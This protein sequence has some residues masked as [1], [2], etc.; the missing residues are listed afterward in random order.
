M[1]ETVRRLP[2]PAQPRQPPVHS[3]LGVND[4]LF[5]LF[6]HKLMIL[7]FAVA[8][9][10]AGITAYF[11]YPPVYES[12]AKLFVRYVMERSGVDPIDSAN[13]A[14][15][16]AVINAEVEILTSW[17]LAVQV[18]DA[19]GPKKMLPEAGDSASKEAA[20]SRV[21]SGLSV[22]GR[23]GSNIILVSYQ[24]RDPQLTMLVLNELV[25]R[26]FNRHLEVH[27]SAGAFDFVTQQTDQVRAR[28]NQ[29]EDALKALKNK[30]GITSLAT[31]LAKLDS[32]LRQTEDKLEAAEGELA[33]QRGKIKELERGKD[34][35]V[36]ELGHS[37]ADQT[38]TQEVPAGSPEPKPTRFPRPEPS[39]NDVQKYES[40]ISQLAQQRRTE[41]ELLARYTTKNLLVE[42][43]RKQ[44]VDLESEQRDLEKKFPSLPARFQPSDPSSQHL[45]LFSEKARLAGIEAKT[46]ALRVRLRRV[47]ERMK[48]FADIGQEIGALE[49]NKELE[50]TNYKYFA[51][52]LEKA[53]IDEALDPSKIPNISTVQRP[54]PPALV[55]KPRDKMA[56]TLSAGGLAVGLALALF[57]ELIL[58]RTI[59]RPSEIEA[60]M[61]IPLL[62]SIPYHNGSNGRRRLP[63]GGASGSSSALVPKKSNHTRI[64]P[65]DANHFMRP[66]FEAIRDRVNL[67]FELHQLTHKPK[68]VGV[69]GF[70][71]GAGASTLAAG[72]A[73]V[74]SE[75]DGGKVLLVDVNLG[76]EDV[77]PFFKGR[78]AYPLRA[79]LQSSTAID[80][81]AE[82]LYLATVGSNAGPAQ[83]G[84]KKFFDLMPNLRA[85]EFDYIIFDMPPLGETSPTVGMAGFMDKLLL[86]VEAEKDNRDL[87][88]RSYRKMAGVRDNISVVFNKAR[89]Y[90]PK[91]LED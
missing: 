62:L 84:L 89:S 14:T 40:V 29:T 32:D 44:I 68:L 57:I 4:I 75:T 3:G 66:Y 30:V 27:R 49:R 54:S 80:S 28:L 1:P 74:M 53:R 42:S 20:A 5:A 41:Q 81:A 37:T 79:A 43:A 58:N 12:Y 23:K 71:E 47:Q 38:V 73:A 65:W 22:S 2:A 82:N 72:L 60:R 10:A 7:L 18:A 85:S 33:E 26:Y 69:T 9:I 83:L 17:D 59:R 56:L 45:D 39:D 67:Y 46:E 21:S 13:A 8:G 19:I 35:P 6:K 16:E 70:S 51:N 15:S 91:Q 77:H 64:A 48:E 87:V 61:H 76:P 36:I 86:V 31:G 90:L 11:W 78:P 24:N 88:E 55:T 25:N 34:S 50:E 52:T 63:G